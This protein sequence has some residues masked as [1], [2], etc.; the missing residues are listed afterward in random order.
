MK[1]LFD[2]VGLRNKKHPTCHTP[3]AWSLEAYNQQVMGRGLFYRER[4]RQRIHFL[5]CGVDLVVGWL[6][7]HR[8]RQHEVGCSK[9]TPP[10]PPRGGGERE[11]RVR[12]GTL[13]QYM[14]SFTEI[15]ARLRCPV[16]G[17]WGTESSRTNIRVHFAFQ[18]PQYSILILEESNQPH[19]CFPQCD[20]FFPQ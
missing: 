10:P 18:H 3:K 20:M 4:I 9:A 5:E 16:E 15:L 8:Q 2:C 12:D 7:T 13:A 19:P 6:T 17:F 11:G 14:V 1:G